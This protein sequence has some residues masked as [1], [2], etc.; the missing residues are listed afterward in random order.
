[1]MIRDIILSIAISAVLAMFVSGLVINKTYAETK[2]ETITLTVPD[3]FLNSSVWDKLVSR[4]K[5]HS[6]KIVTL[7]WRGFGGLNVVGFR[8]IDNLKEIQKTQTVNINI[9]GEAISMHALTLCYVDN[10]R[11]ANNGVMIFH[12]IFTRDVFGK[13]TY[14][15]DTMET[16]D[17]CI[18]KGYL[19]KQDVSDMY[20]KELRIEVYKDMKKI[21]KKDWNKACKIVPR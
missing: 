14:V 18:K 2:Q 3:E 12:P 7:D 13:K 17:P 1:M 11:F 20:H 4:I 10:V 9:T 6:K 15:M 19:S 5:L 8:F 16:F 21:C